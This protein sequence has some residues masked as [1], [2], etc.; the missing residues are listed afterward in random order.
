M[1]SGDLVLRYSEK[2]GGQVDALI[3]TLGDIDTCGDSG[4]SEIAYEILKIP[5]DYNQGLLVDPSFL[6]SVSDIVRSVKNKGDVRDAL[7]TAKKYPDQTQHIITNLGLASRHLTEEEFAAA[8]TE[9]K[10][11]SD[12][13]HAIDAARNI[14]IKAIKK[15]QE[16]KFQLIKKSIEALGYDDPLVAGE[17]FKRF[18]GDSFNDVY[19]RA[20]EILDGNEGYEFYKNPEVISAI[21]SYKGPAA[22]GVARGLLE[23]LD[24][25]AKSVEEEAQLKKEDGDF[26][27]D[28]EAVKASAAFMSSKETIEALQKLDVKTAERVIENLCQLPGVVGVD[29]ASVALKTSAGLRNADKFFETLRHLPAW[30]GKSDI[31]NIYIALQKIKEKNP[32]T[33][34][35]LVGYLYSFDFLGDKF[36]GMLNYF[37]R[38]KSIKE[39]ET[40][41]RTLSSVYGSSM[42]PT[43]VG[44]VKMPDTTDKSWKALIKLLDYMDAFQ[45]SDLTLDA[46]E[47]LYKSLAAAESAVKGKIKSLGITDEEKGMRF[48]PW[49]KSGYEPAI[50]VLKGEKISKPWL[51]RTYPV[52]SAPVDLKSME[53]EIKLYAKMIGEEISFDR[54]EDLQSLRSSARR[55][56]SAASKKRGLDK[57]VLGEAKPNLNRILSSTDGA[58]GE[59]LLSIDASDMESQLAALQD[60]SSCL[61]PGATNFE[62]T[63]IL[64]E[65]PNTLFPL[66]KEAG[67][68]KIVGILSIAK[69]IHGDKKVI[70]RWSQIHS[71][72]PLDEKSV[73]ESLK[74]YAAENGIEFLLEGEM[75]V[76]GI[77]EMVMDDYARGE[78]GKVVVDRNRKP[79]ELE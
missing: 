11:C 21:K 61:S 45:D 37:S 25:P 40:V 39:I 1:N 3:K 27:V 12:V 64:L 49:V 53:E 63:K 8:A 74:K 55:L 57:K 15:N 26:I 9:I 10:N 18:K 50:K 33:A 41:G 30:C 5:S 35:V 66:I 19:V 44:R 58:G 60:I 43:V 59:Y 34:E 75:I 7:E 20:D 77:G 46:S 65:N 17:L 22:V 62:Y 51:S 32:E 28:P 38:S 31:E 47:D 2:F 72:V 79:E 42:I 6:G 78:N 13:R 36:G 56:I 23:A 16:C 54:S 68:G 69:G 76:D 29:S 67:S 70:S 4:I 14:R 48:F 24:R 71:T 52:K 73:D